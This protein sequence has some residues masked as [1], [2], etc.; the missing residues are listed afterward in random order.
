[1]VVLKDETDST[2]ANYRGFVLEIPGITTTSTLYIGS[3]S[4]TATLRDVQ[5]G[6][7]YTDDGTNG[8]YGAITPSVD[9]D[10]SISWK[11]TV[12]TDG[13]IHIGYGHTDGEEYFVFGWLLDSSNTYAD[14][15]SIFKDMNGEW[16]TICADGT[17]GTG[18]YYDSITSEW[19]AVTNMNTN[20]T[21][22]F[23][24]LRGYNIDTS[25]YY[26]NWQKYTTP[27]STDIR[28]AEST[29]PTQGDYISVPGSSDIFVKTSGYWGPWIRY[30]PS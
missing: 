20:M 27:K 18:A 28:F 8:G 9:A 13:T 24:F 7:G 12:T 16:A 1:M 17:V 30:T 3:Y 23:T 26:S 5:I 2:T 10:T 19:R 25:I 11:N 15:I 21:T 22:H 14:F 6:T 4:D 29:T